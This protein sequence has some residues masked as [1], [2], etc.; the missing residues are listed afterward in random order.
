MVEYRAA[1][2]MADRLADPSNYAGECLF[3]AHNGLLERARHTSAIGGRADIK[4]AVSD[5]R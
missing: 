5:F 2:K 3:L 4:D 1:G